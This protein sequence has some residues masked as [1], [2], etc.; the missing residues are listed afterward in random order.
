M[1]LSPGLDAGGHY[2][3]HGLGEGRAYK[4]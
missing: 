1:S 3:L 4:V 2:V